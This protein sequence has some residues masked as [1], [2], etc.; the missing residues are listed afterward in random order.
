[1]QSKTPALRPTFM[2]GSVRSIGPIQS[3]H[4]AEALA[5][6]TFMPTA[7]ILSVGEDLSLSGSQSHAWQSAGYRVTPAGSIRD[8]I[9]H[10]RYG[11]YDLV[12]LGDSIRVGDR[13]RL[14]FLIRALGSRVP[15]VCV[16]ASPGDCAGFADATT[17]SEPTRLLQ[18]VGEMLAQAKKPP[19]SRTM[20]ARGLQRA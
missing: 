16:T 2:P 4:F 11:D 18:C 8:A 13:E 9:D 19:A 15:V 20:S 6:T 1:M 12:L 5:A 7:V 17:H 3:A 10:I 14:T